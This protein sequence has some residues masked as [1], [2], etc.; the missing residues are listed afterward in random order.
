MIKVDRPS[1]AR[2][3]RRCGLAIPVLA[4]ALAACGSSGG[5]PAGAPSPPP[6]VG[7]SDG[8]T[9]HGT[10]YVSG[11]VHNRPTTWHVLKSF[12]QRV[13]TVQNC[14]AAAKYGMAAGMFRVP[15]PAA[16]LPVANIEVT[17]FRGPGSY[18]PPLLK[19]D[20]SDTI[21]LGQ[22]TG[23][24]SGTYVITTSARGAPQGKEALVVYKDGSGQLD[25][26]EAH[27]KGSTS[28]PA[29]AGVI[30]WKCTS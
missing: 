19:R 22:T 18:P 3:A 11:L 16:P 12:T 17:G 10:I 9:F 5:Q 27:L 15:S 7:P 6:A 25:Y 28:S 14:A 26:S 29:L 4:L 8:A 23:M 24:K 20:K 13:A 1:L 2:A 21:S 30:L